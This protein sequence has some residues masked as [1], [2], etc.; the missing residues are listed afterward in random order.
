MVSYDIFHIIAFCRTILVYVCAHSA[1]YPS[2]V[3]NVWLKINKLI[4]KTLNL[5]KKICFYSECLMSMSLKAEVRCFANLL[6]TVSGLCFCKHKKPADTQKSPRC[7]GWNLCQRLFWQPPRSSALDFYSIKRRRRR[8]SRR[9][10]VTL[11]S[12]WQQTIG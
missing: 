10:S 7:D 11:L 12:E 3:T 1:H 6:M 5:K 4:N 2:L 8:S 9:L